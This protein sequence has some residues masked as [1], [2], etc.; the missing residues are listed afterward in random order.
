M[1]KVFISYARPNRHDVAQL[2]EHR[3]E[4]ACDAW[5]DTFSNDRGGG[6]PATFDKV[7]RACSITATW[8]DV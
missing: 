5:A 4:L 2:D 8:F 6:R 7:H 1:R 3:R